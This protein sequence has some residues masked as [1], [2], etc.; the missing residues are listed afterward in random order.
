MAIMVYKDYNTSNKSFLR[1]VTI[2]TKLGIKNN[3]F[4]AGTNISLTK[5]AGAVTINSTS[6]GSVTSVGLTVPTGL[7]VSNSPIT[8]SGVL[9]IGLDTG[10]SIPTIA[11]QTNWNTA[12][13]NYLN[14]DGGSTNLNAVTGRTSLGA[15]TLGSN[16]FTITNPD[17][18]TYPRFNAAASKA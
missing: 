2:L 1:M 18:I 3:D 10:Y 8:S 12:Y 4:K 15:T 16:L 6:S 9:G 17:A 5:V 14:W 13:S 11:N 7:T